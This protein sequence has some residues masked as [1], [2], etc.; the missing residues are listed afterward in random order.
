[1]T[2]SDSL[3]KSAYLAAVALTPLL[4]A[5]DAAG[6]AEQ[7]HIAGEQIKPLLNENGALY[8]E[9]AQLRFIEAFE[10]AETMLA[11]HIPDSQVRANVITQ[12][13]QDVRS[14][15][16]DAEPRGGLEFGSAHAIRTSAQKFLTAL[17]AVI[18]AGFEHNFANDGA[19][20]PTVPE[21]AAENEG[22][23]TAE[24]TGI[25]THTKDPQTPNE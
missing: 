10:A 7:T 12:H 17:Q 8:T 24:N 22:A 18:P 3:L 2:T 21:V 23:A 14:L 15:A 16:H 5:Y 13:F 20:N 6:E 9:I 25:A 4:G 1:M 11:P 19:S